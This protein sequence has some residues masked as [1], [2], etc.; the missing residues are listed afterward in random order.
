LL[1]R[2]VWGASP[3]KLIGQNVLDR[4]PEVERPKVLRC[5]DQVFT[6]NARTACEITGVNDDW[7]RWYNLKFSQPH[8]ADQLV[9]SW[10]TTTT[11]TTTTTIVIR[12]ISEQK[13]TE[14]RLRT[15]GEEIREFAARLEGVREEERTRVAREIHDELGQALTIL[16][17]DLSWVQSRIP[18]AA[19]TRRKMKEIIAH[20]DDT[21]ERVRRISSELRPAILDDLGLIPAIEWQI[22]EFRKRTGIRTRVISK[23]EGL[24]L[25]RD[26]AA[27]VFRVVQEALTNVMRHAEA[28]RLQV[29]LKLKDHEFRI[30]I[31]DNGVGM[32]RSAES[33]LSSLGILGMKERIIRLGGHFNI[34][35][36]PGQGTQLDIAIPA[37][38]D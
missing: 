16:K 31:Q 19:A 27:A 23:A 3:K 17:L 4:I 29:E 24:A 37:Q 6:Y 33:G 11:T 30:S 1:N 13:Q 15:S 5:L 7:D 20:V 8:A 9:P 12:E 28:S 36:E 21:I 14:K 26:T 22:G 2:P 10:L 25:P 38:H 35:S 34:V 32:K 18:A